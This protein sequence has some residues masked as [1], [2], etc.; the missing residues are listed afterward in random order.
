MTQGLVAHSTNS[1]AASFFVDFSGMLRPHDHMAVCAPSGE[2]AG[3]ALKPTL[4][5]T[6]D[7][8]GSTKIEAKRLASGPKV[9][10][11]PWANWVVASYQ[12]KEVT[13]GADSFISSAQSLKPFSTAGSVK[14][15]FQFSSK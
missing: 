6:V 10:A 2:A 12:S 4:S 3:S 1:Q 5:T 9:A 15:G 11:L 8:F 7:C 14:R 13:P